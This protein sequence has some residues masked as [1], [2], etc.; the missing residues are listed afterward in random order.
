MPA[1]PRSGRV[2]LGP[3][4]GVPRTLAIV[5]LCLLAGLGGRAVARAQQ[6][7]WRAQPP[8][9]SRALGS[10]N[11][12]AEPAAG[13]SGGQPRT[14][15][16]RAAWYESFESA[17]PTW[18]PVGATGPYQIVRHQRT[19]EQPHTGRQCEWL[20][21]HARAGTRVFL[22]HDAGRAR[23]IEDLLPTVWVKSDRGGV[24]LA[25]R[26][27]LP[28][29]LDPR[30]GQPAAVLL[31]GSR[32][33]GA[34]QWQQLRL[35]DLPRLLARQVR[36]LRAEWESDVDPRGAWV[37]SMVLE[38]SAG[39]DAVNLWIDDLD[40]AGFVSASQ[41]RAGP[42][43]HPAGALGTRTGSGHLEAGEPG[44]QRRVEMLG[45]TLVADGH[46]FFL[47]AIEYRGEPLQRLQALGFNAVWLDE[48]PSDAL[49]AEA[50]RLGLWLVAAPPASAGVQSAEI[51]AGQSIAPQFGQVLAWNL[52]RGLSEAQLDALRA[53]ADAVRLADRANR[54]LVCDA[55]DA[56]RGF[57]RQVDLLLLDR[58]PMGTSSELADYGTWLVMQQRLARPG[59][60]VWT[61]IQT[62]P[63]AA[64]RAQL[65]AI[66]P[67]RAPPQT[68]S[69]EQ[70]R[71]SALAALA[72]GSRG[73]LFLSDTPLTSDD[74][75]TRYRAEALQLLNAELELIGPWAAT[76]TLQTT[77][78]ASEPLLL[79]AVLRAG[80]TRLVLP[81][82]FDPQAQHVVG[83]AALNGLSLV[84]PGV[85]ESVRA[86]ELMPGRVEPLEQKRVTGGLRIGWGEF[87][88]ATAVVLAQDPVVVDGLKRRAAAAG[89]L[90]AALKHDLALAR[91]EQVEEVLGQLRGH[92]PVPAQTTAW[93]SAAR[94]SLEG[95]GRQLQA[96]EPAAAYLFARRAGRMLRLV[97]RSC[98][99]TAV[100]AL[101]SPATSPGTSTFAALPWH[102]RLLDRLGGSRLGPNLLGGGEFEDLH[103]LMAA[104]WR[105]T[106]Q[107]QPG[108]ESFADL[109]P[110][111][112]HSGRTGLRLVAR[113][114][115]P[116]QAPGA[117]EGPAVWITSAPVQVPSGALVC[118]HGWVLVREPVVGSVDGL[119]IVDSIG[120]E[121]LA[122]RIRG[123]NGW[124]KFVLYRTAPCSGPVHV[125]FAL[126]G[127]GEVWL[128]DVAVSVLE[129]VGT[130]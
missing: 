42:R 39:P 79:S 90:A 21:I 52:G 96:G 8:S 68:V 33:T 112:A 58:R 64:L 27:V 12:G 126:S 125:T 45:T 97:E 109:V 95:S 31:S 56:V 122:E 88:L 4:H 120:G 14:P 76:G 3:Q 51:A 6:A 71:L 9:A 29:T 67:D 47:R 103:A 111:A 18:Q 87:D 81:L 44:A 66:W 104:G 74:P 128:D 70:L 55:R 60:P 43:V 89:S 40:I 77:A 108:V 110:E 123:T 49:L 115:D 73:L 7:G 63:T 48:V 124:Q 69:E 26:V 107:P 82:W 117:V 28:D 62:Q 91:Y 41:T 80:R 10:A 92:L 84:V 98:W 54:P 13:L 37:E 23:V 102:V 5:C 59:T 105:H 35:A 19:A 94:Q 83:Q 20:Q 30:T 72:S 15:L 24:Q 127:M 46:P 101:P 2:A 85:P 53:R 65:R 75:Q 1:R 50:A 16:P 129:P 17:Q 116:E 93:M 113:P 25:A 57:S 32:Y 86:Y 99:Q 106:Q 121:D 38:V 118:V 34:G 119:L 61:T 78:Q 100:E 22:G 130:N 11:P 114:A 36:V